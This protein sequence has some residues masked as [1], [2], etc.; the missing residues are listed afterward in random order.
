VN[1][2]G[3]NTGP[4]GQE[5]GIGFAIVLTIVT[6]GIYAIYWLYK[7]FSETRNHR[8]EGLHPIVGV[9]LCLVIVG[10]FLLSQAI[11]RMYNAEG[12]ENPPV[13][14]LTGLWLFV[15]YVGTFIYIAKVQGALNAY[16]K[17]KG[18][19]TVQAVPASTT[20]I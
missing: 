18:A 16:W 13:S 2:T 20:G 5:R 19:G 15:P 11:G 10:Y 6:L 4:L 12:H 17:A 9:L 7:S 14:G 1:A 8:G 3:Q